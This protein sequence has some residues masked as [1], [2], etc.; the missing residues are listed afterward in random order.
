MD[1][2]CISPLI[3]TYPSKGVQRNMLKAW[4]FTKNKFCHRFFDKNLQKFFQRNIVEN[5]NGQIRFIV[6]M[7]CAI[8]HYLYNIKKREKHPWRSVNFSI[9]LNNFTSQSVRFFGSVSEVLRAQTR[10]IRIGHAICLFYFIFYLLF[11]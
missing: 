4:D 11:I 5:G 10:P 8:W 1:V 6:V 2:I 9:I 3:Q 7:R